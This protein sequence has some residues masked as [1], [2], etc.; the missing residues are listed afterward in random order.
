MKVLFLPDEKTTDAP[1][2]TILQAGERAGVHIVASCGGHF[3]CGKCKVRIMPCDYDKLPPPDDAEVAA[4]S[5]DELADGIRLACKVNLPESGSITVYT[6]KVYDDLSR[7]ERITTLPSHFIANFRQYDINDYGIAFDIG[8]TTVVGMLCSFCEGS[9]TAA[10]ARTNP[11]GIYG[12]DVISRI[13]YA[14]QSP[15]HLKAAQQKVIDCFNEII[16]TLISETTVKC[17]QIKEVTVVGNTTMSH[18]FLGVD[19][20]CLARAPF[21]P[22]FT[23]A[24]T[25]PA[26]TLGLHLDPSTNVYVLPNIAGHVGSDITGV[27]LAANLCELPGVNLVIDIGTNGE[28]LLSQDGEMLACATAAGPALEGASIRF[29]M[30]AAIGAIEG[31]D[32]SGDDIVLNVIGDASPIGICGSGLIS[33]IAQMLNIGLLNEKGKLLDRASALEKGI[34]S[35]IAN[36]LYSDDAGSGFVVSGEIAL[37]QKDIREVQL[38]KGAIAAGISVLLSKMNLCAQD[39]DNVLIA[40][41]F[42]NYIRIEDALRVG[43]IPPVPLERISLI[44]N[45]AGIGACMALLSVGHRKL[46]EFEAEKI[47]H[48][49]LT[50][51]ASFV[52]EHMRAM[53]FPKG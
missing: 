32:L 9:I 17:E 46:S 21:N 27:M 7:K 14:E 22:V 48:I 26:S 47:T 39:I 30:R 18:L 23:N 4:L 43:L 10:V 8:T 44:G 13:Q 49:D 37:T 34:S 19:P 15:E 29:G 40:G 3:L 12:A 51:E 1:S 28:V 16:D 11:Q 36:R 5:Q 53:Y 41:A 50:D 24:V 52:N 20:S 6:S 25:T 42:G 45:A 31:A 38:A 2:M 35:Q 33:L